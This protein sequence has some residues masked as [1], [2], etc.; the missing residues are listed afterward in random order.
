MVALHGVVQGLCTCGDEKCLNP[1][2]HPLYRNWQKIPIRELGVW[3]HIA[4]RGQPTNVGLATGR[5]SGVFALDHDPKNVVDPAAVQALLDQLPATWTQRTG[6]GGRHW[7][8]LMPADFEP[9]NSAGS[10]PKGLDI[11]G[12]G[13]Q[14][15]IAPSVTDK[16]PYTV[17][18]DTPPLAA[19]SVLLEHL[20]PAPYTPRPP[21]TPGPVTDARGAAYAGRAGEAL[22]TELREESSTRNE[23]AYKVA[24]RLHELINAGWLD[25]DVTYDAYLSACEIASGNK[26]EPFTQTEAHHVWQNAAHR[27][28]DKAAELPPSVLGGT[29]L[30]FPEARMDS[31]GSMPGQNTPSSLPYFANPGEVPTTSFATSTPTADQP[32]GLNLPPEFW[33][34]RPVLRHIQLAAHSR[35][36]SADVLLHSILVRLSALWPHRVR[37]DTGIATPASA[38]LTVAVVGP[39]G[40]GKTSGIGLAR[41]VLPAPGWLDRET[42]ADDRPLGSGEGMSEVY[43]GY[44]R[45]PVEQPPDDPLTPGPVK[46]KMEKVRTQ[47]RHNA[48]LHADEGEAL[49]KMMERQGATVAVELRRAW[50]GGTIGQSN[51]TKETTRVIEEGQY[52]MGLIIGFQLNTVQ[53]LLASV[54]AGT[55]QRFLFCWALD[56]SVSRERLPDPGPLRG[57]WPAA[58]PL[59]GGLVNPEPE[60]DLRKV[61]FAPVILDE[62]WEARFGRVTTMPETME[63]L[64]SHRSVTLVKLSA[65][66][67]YL[68]CGRRNVT[69]EDWRLAGMVWDTS[70]R[71]RDYAIETGRQAAGKAAELRK[72][73][74]ADQEAHAELRRIDVRQSADDLK[75]VKVARWAARYVAAHPQVTAGRIKR[76]AAGR[77]APLVAEALEHALAVGWLTLNIDLYA[78]GPISP[79]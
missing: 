24:A 10:L 6:S 77:N 16:G 52:S 29:R 78:P 43:M 51:G 46:I 57:I 19:P 18:R 45:V 11:R 27:V 25:Y 71:V 30:D 8:F 56:P 17:L 58:T 40:A 76:D 39:S 41:R 44:R 36:V 13:G 3:Q 28:G 67:A 14:I 35:L 5:H 54:E 48:L 62:V 1:G 38:N 66:L 4:A 37:L 2:K 20:R 79:G 49:A 47:V 21:S 59:E 65:L 61:T 15:V 23:R 32:A 68:D 53:Q 55:V 42:F 50:S 69:E 73:F 70:C 63:D 9:T 74:Y 33:A 64:T 72:A 26:R 22:L 75:I 7:L 12:T 60:E 34:A 31:G